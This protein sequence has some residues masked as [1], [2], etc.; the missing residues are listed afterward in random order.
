MAQKPQP[1][2]TVRVE[3]VEQGIED[4]SLGDSAEDLLTDAHEMQDI[5]RP[6]SPLA[7]NRPLGVHT[8]LIPIP[9]QVQ[10]FIDN[11]NSLGDHPDRPAFLHKI[12]SD[13]RAKYQQSKSETDLSL[14]LECGHTA[15]TSLRNG[16]LRLP[17]YLHNYARSVQCVWEKTHTTET[18]EQMIYY[19]KR[20]LEASPEGN[21]SIPLYLCDVGYALHRR[22][23]VK[24]TLQDLL[25]A[26][27]YYQ[28]S[29][30][31]RPLH[32]SIKAVFCN[33]L[34]ASLRDE[35]DA[36]GRVEAL[37]EAIVIQENVIE[38]LPD[39]TPDTSNRIIY[40]N[41]GTVYRRK[42]QQTHE[43]SHIDNAIINFSKAL[44]PPQP[45]PS[46]TW[47]G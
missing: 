43:S 13:S 6:Q 15:F 14:A 32:V 31:Q 41:L 9:P 45:N 21:I 30:T 24:G 5:P 8:P 22:F 47:S 4:I 35:F 28:R 36:V 23:E 1:D 46:T 38:S 37:D 16:D 11:V 10:A 7:S 33:N 3:S 39:K 12:S 34:V 27:T 40:R 20:A 26:K 18:L 44:E 42:F 19:Y 2:A 25:D 17:A 29:L